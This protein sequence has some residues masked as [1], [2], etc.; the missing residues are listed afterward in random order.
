MNLWRLGANVWGIVTAG[1]DLTVYLKKGIPW[2]SDVTGTTDQNLISMIVIVPSS[3]NKLTI[4]TV[5]ID[6]Y[7]VVTRFT[8]KI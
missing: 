4:A 6:H 5:G 2:D 7:H 3:C 8:N 1:E